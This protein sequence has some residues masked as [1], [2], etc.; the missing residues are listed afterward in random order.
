MP[1]HL[2]VGKVPGSFHRKVA[3]IESLLDI[4]FAYSGDREYTVTKLSQSCLYIRMVE[5]FL[6]VT[7][8]KLSLSCLYF[9][10][11][12][13]SICV[14]DVNININIDIIRDNSKKVQGSEV[15]VI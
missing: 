8:M 14:T 2:E 12:E 9:G 5:V 7:D 15:L 11:V 1:C 13:V 4:L 6:C 10:T 3:F